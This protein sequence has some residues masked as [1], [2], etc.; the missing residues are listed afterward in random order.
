MLFKSH[1]KIPTNLLD[2][3]MNC[4]YLNY[5][6]SSSEKNIY[7][8]EWLSKS[9]DIR[10]SYTLDEYTIYEDI[11]KTNYN[12]DYV[13]SDHYMD[14]GCGCKACNIKRRQLASKIAKGIPTNERIVHTEAK[15][16]LITRR[17]TQVNRINNA[18]R[19]MPPKPR[20]KDFK[21]TMQNVLIGRIK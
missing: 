8:N 3:V 4:K 7:Y 19:N 6:Y 13:Q 12:I 21:A 1:Y 10:N 17:V 9:T 16:E 14:E 5:Y 18:I 15:T 20:G 2:T 11:T